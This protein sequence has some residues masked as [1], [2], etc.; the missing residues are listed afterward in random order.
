[1]LPNKKWEEWKI[2]RK[3]IPESKHKKYLEEIGREFKIIEDTG[4]SDYF[5]IDYKV[6]KEDTTVRVCDSSTTGTTSVTLSTAAEA[7]YY[8]NGEIL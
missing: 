1:M 7:G 3:D 4:M 8:K 2:F 6:V 5:L